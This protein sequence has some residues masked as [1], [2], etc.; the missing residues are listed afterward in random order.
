M[1]VCGS[2]SNLNIFIA[3]KPNSILILILKNWAVLLFRKIKYLLT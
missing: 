1:S 3:Y 2:A